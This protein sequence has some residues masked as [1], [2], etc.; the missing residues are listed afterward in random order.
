M[1]DASDAKRVLG[2][3]V[4]GLGLAALAPDAWLVRASL[5][6]IYALAVL[7]QNLLMGYAGQVS[8]GQAGFLATGAYAFA[9]LRAIG[10]PFL[11]ALLLASGAAALVGVLVGL[12]SLRLRGAY[13][14][15]ATL[16]FSMAVY[17]LLAGSDLLSGG[18]AGLA[19]PPLPLPSGMSRTVGL[20][21]IALVFVVLATLAVRNLVSSYVG[22]T[23]VAVRDADLAAASLG[24]DVVRTKLTAFAVSSFLTGASGALLAQFLGHLEPQGFTLT[25]SVTLV[26]AVV[27]GGLASI[28]GSLLGAAFVVLVPTLGTETSWF[29]PVTHGLALLFVLSFQPEGLA[30]LLRRLRSM[31]PEGAPW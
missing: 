13:L 15:V 4:F 28:P 31:L 9:H 20:Y 16:G 24:V 25:E 22:R 23:A 17:H 3:L 26:V 29:V 2:V 21:G 5:I 6:F 30:G 12:P 11:L 14:A 7:G 18:R 19:V 1:R 27:V 8:F 10:A